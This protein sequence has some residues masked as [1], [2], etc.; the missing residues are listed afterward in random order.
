[1]GLEGYT[2]CADNIRTM[3]ESPIMV[4]NE[5]HRVISQEN[6]TYVWN[7]LYEF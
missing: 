7:L 6:D 3:V 4:A 5:T 1:M 2:L